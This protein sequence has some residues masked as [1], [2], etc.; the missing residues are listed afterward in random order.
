MDA[1]FENIA[2]KWISNK[3]F[4]V[5][6]M[7][8]SAVLWGIWKLRNSLCFQGIEWRNGNQL[9]KIVIGMLNNWKCLCKEEDTQFFMEMLNKIQKLSDRPERILM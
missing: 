6:N 8:S 2:A 4:L 7:F 3:R 5:R 9:W 1:N